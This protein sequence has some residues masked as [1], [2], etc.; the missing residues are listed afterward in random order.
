MKLLNNI[1]TN[2]CANVYLV[3]SSDDAQLQIIKCTTLS[4]IVLTMYH[5][6]TCVFVKDFVETPAFGKIQFYCLFFLRQH[7][8]SHL[9][10]YNYRNLI[11]CNVKHKF[12]CRFA[13][14]K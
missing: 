13:N 14:E 5:F 11:I 1:C 2:V 8:V 9:Y 4:V 3:V 10:T 6:L 12:V 7:A